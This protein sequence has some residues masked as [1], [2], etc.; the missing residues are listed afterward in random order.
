MVT[1]SFSIPKEEDICWICKQVECKHLKTT[2]SYINEYFTAY[3]LIDKWE[4][5]YEEDVPYE[6]KVSIA[7]HFENEDQKRR[8]YIKRLLGAMEFKFYQQPSFV[9]APYIPITPMK[10]Y[11]PED[12]FVIWDPSWQ[13]FPRF[14]DVG[15]EKLNKMIVRSITR[16]KRWSK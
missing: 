16:K 12:R 9:Y 7:M 3:D 11:K 1:G 10:K 8:L 2:P 13:D 5:Q 4:S 15:S 6:L 14:F